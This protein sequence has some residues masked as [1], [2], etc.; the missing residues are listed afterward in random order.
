MKLR[1]SKHLTAYEKSLIRADYTLLNK[2]DH[3]TTCALV[4]AKHRVH[5]ATVRLLVHSWPANLPE[6]TP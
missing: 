6:V 2:G 3:E 5:D 1:E 4:A